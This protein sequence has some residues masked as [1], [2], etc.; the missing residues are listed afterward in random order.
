MY[1]LCS[2]KRNPKKQVL[3]ENDH[4]GLQNLERGIDVGARHG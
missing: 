3:G 4:S 2:Q 1:T